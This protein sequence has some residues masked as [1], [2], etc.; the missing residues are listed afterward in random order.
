[1]QD[2][3]LSPEAIKTLVFE[4]QIGE[5][6]YGT[7]HR[8]LLPSTG[9]IYAAKVTEIYIQCDKVEDSP[10]FQTM[11]QEIDIL[12]ASRSCPQIVHIF[13]VDLPTGASPLRLMV[14]MELCHH[15]SL[16]DILRKL[17]CGFS[18]IAIRIITREVLLG[19]KYLHDDHMIH[20]D[21]KAGN[22]LVTKGFQPKLA[23]FGVSCELQN[24]FARRNT[25][26]GSPYWMAPE[27]IRGIEYNYTA[28]IWSLGIT[29]IEVAECQPPYWHI[30]PLPAM[31]VIST[32]PPKG[33]MSTDPETFSK[34]FGEFLSACLTVNQCKRP[35]ASTLLEREFAQP[36]ENEPF[37]AQA[38]QRYL[39]PRLEKASIEGISVPTA[40]KTHTRGNSFQRRSTRPTGNSLSL[41]NVQRSPVQR[42]P[43]TQ[44]SI[45]PV[46][47]ACPSDGDDD[48][49]EMKKEMRRRAAAWVNSMVPMELDEDDEPESPLPMKM[50][51]PNH[52]SNQPS[53]P[54]WN[55]PSNHES[56]QPA[57]QACI[58][59]SN[60]ILNQTMNQT[61]NQPSNQPWTQPSHQT[62]NQPSNQ[63][64]NQPSDQPP[65]QSSNNP[66]NQPWTHSSNQTTTQLS[67]QLWNQPS[68]QT[69]NQPSNQPWN[70]PSNQPWS[71]PPNQPQNLPWNQPSNQPWN[72][73]GNQPS[74]QPPNQPWNQPSNQPPNQLSNQPRNSPPNQA[75]NQSPRQNFGSRNCNFDA[76][77]SDDEGVQT[78]V[79]REDEPEAGAGA[80]AE[81]TPLFMIQVSG[82][83][84]KPE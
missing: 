7:V 6:S 77:D 68:N 26:I 56:N 80:P 31:F 3:Q 25:Q 37:P 48:E 32:K 53:S 33:L 46:V 20:R 70:Q 27:V 65:N 76:W 41:S 11:Q 84:D 47:V 15:G 61:S 52:T 38:L 45:A 71:Q 24:T 29:C 30:P 35:S 62:W 21:V 67:N 28:D 78:R 44:P 60:R 14:V 18:E 42:S 82:D 22:I 72:Q 34:S 59:P 55:Q 74:N 54:P 58:E 17:Q 9:D 43:V 12:K 16:S 1:M 66:S 75:S 49:E 73:V 57:N 63:P 5:G 4:Q 19:L 81:A 36:L 64:W 69:S 79:R 83:V 2:D 39:A 23:D 50:P 51:T 10:A 13:G 8:A 40:S